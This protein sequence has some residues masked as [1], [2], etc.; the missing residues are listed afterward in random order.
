MQFNQI[1][2]DKP[3]LGLSLALGGCGVRLS[4]LTAMYSNF[5]NKGQFCPLKFLKDGSQKTEPLQIVSKSSAYLVTDVLQKLNRPDFTN[6]T[7]NIVDI[8][9]IAW[10]TGT[11]YGRK[12][13]WSIG[14]NNTYTVGVWVGNFS[15]KGVPELTG[16]E[17]AT[18]LLFS[19]FKQISKNN[20]EWNFPPA[21]LKHTWVCSETGHLP[22]EKCEHQILDFHLPL[23]TK[24]TTCSHLIDVAVNKDASVSYCKHCVPNEHLTK[25]YNNYSPAQIAYYES[26][27]TPCQKIPPH[28]SNCERYY[29]NESLKIISPKAN[30]DY[31]FLKDDNDEI[32]LQSLMA[33]GVKQVHWYINDS[34][35]TSSNRSDAT[36]FKPATG[37]NKITCVDDKGR[38][39]SLFIDVF[40]L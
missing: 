16:A 23:V 14:Y 30:V 28:N 37:K 2:K 19:V 12:D 22:S 24:Q 9:N 11:S 8:P 25:N 27:N 21:E 40:Y 17:M 35:F 38:S 13:A 18:P 15:G 20:G 6:N 32:L 36:F 39:S 3:K 7:G 29:A 1:V 10:K 34:Y 33:A 26:N 31:Y 5:A 4:E